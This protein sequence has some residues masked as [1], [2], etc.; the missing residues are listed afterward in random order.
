VTGLVLASTVPRGI[1]VSAHGARRALSMA[2][3]LVGSA[4]HAEACLVRRVLSGREPLPAAR[5]RLVAGELVW[6]LD[7]EAARR[8]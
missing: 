6:L 1:E 5:V 2:R 8:L 7:A 3:C 4:A